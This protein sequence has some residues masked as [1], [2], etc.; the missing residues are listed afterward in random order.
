MKKNLLLFILLAVAAISCNM[1]PKHTISGRLD[2]MESD[3]LLVFAYDPFRNIN[4]MTDTVALDKGRFHSDLPDSLLLQITI[5]QKPSGNQAMRMAAHQPIIILPGDHLEISGSITDMVLSGTEI[6]D[7]MRKAVK[8]KQMQAKVKEAGEKVYALYRENEPDRSAIDSAMDYLQS[9]S[10]QLAEQKYEYIRE[11]PD[12]MESGFMYLSLSS[13]KGVEA[14][15]I[16][17]GKVKNGPLGGLI[18]RSYR[19]YKSAIAV[20]KAKE[21]IQKGKQAP[22]FSL[23]DIKGRT[24]SLSSFKGEYV[25]LDFWGSWC[26]WCI[27]GIPD[28]KKYYG[29]YGNKFEIIGIACIDTE[30]KWREAVKKYGLPWTNLFNGEDDNVNTLYAVSGYPTKILVDPEGRIEEIFVGESEDLYNKLDEMF[31]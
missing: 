19:S 3:T 20:E 16:L 5:I 28:M 6:Y 11:H 1:S 10:R 9:V 2:G 22:D 4:V 14:Y 15:D 12:N 21:R 23:K 27:K 30:Q 31:K 7:G 24:V 18:S 26:S 25:L 8:V 13:A 29:K 17:G